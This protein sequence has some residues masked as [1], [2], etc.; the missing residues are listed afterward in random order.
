ME[1]LVYQVQEHCMGTDWLRQGEG[2]RALPTSQVFGQPDGI[3]TLIPSRDCL[4]R[5]CSAFDGCN[6]PAHVSLQPA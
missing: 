3:S 4:L 2:I 1:I 5:F 6:V